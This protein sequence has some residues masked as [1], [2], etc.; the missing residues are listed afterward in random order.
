MNFSYV[1]SFRELERASETLEYQ[2][3]DPY[4]ITISLS[5]KMRGY[6]VTL[7]CVPPPNKSWYGHVEPTLWL[8]GEE[9]CCLSQTNSP[10]GLHCFID[11]HGR[12]INLKVE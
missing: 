3:S 5:G 2:D 11:N 4:I 8:N 12:A 6:V 9:V 7:A 1:L 10:K